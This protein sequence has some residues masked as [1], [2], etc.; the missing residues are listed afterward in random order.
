MSKRDYYE[1]LGVDR[2]ADPQTIKKAFRRLAQQYH[3][4][5][6]RS[7]DAEA[8][9]K[10]IN[11]AYQ[12]LS[13][14]EKR[15]L[16][17]R[18]GH[19][20]FD[21]G[22]RGAPDFGDLGG[23][24]DLGSIF[25]EFFAG[26][27]GMGGRARRSGA[28]RGADLRVDVTLSF[29]EAAFGTERE[30]TVP[31]LEICEHCRGTGAEPGTSPQR[32]ST[33]GGRG[34]VQH[35]RQ[36]PL[37]GMIITAETCPTCNG[38]G[39]VIPTPCSKCRGRKRVQ[40]E[41]TIKVNIPA[42]VD[43]GTRIRLTGEGEAGLQGGPPGNLY[44]VIHVEPHPIFV[45]EDFDIHMELPIN[46]AQAA[47]GARVQIPTLDGHEETL[48]IPPGT[49]SGTTFRKRGLGIPRLQRSGR[50]DMLVTVRVEIPTKLTP[51]QR[52]LFRRL[53]ES[54]EDNTVNNSRRGFLDRLLHPDS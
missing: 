52:E 48:E 16:Y 6:N 15:A 26:F 5:V 22:G 17:D 54:F 12:V 36:S 4:D 41:R 44:V 8:K 3:P 51:E 23:F 35:R 31:R 47:L 49:Q 39:E 28:R 45:R 24:G 29:E 2:S 20:A 14:P 18:L 10:E 21:P 1:V 40:V 37:F 33:C 53:A 13:D 46:V 25:E 38:T 27:T 11:E 7:P 42:G 9:F 50:G 32:C 30:I 43:D 34:E 19:A